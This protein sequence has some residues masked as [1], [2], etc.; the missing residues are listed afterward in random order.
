MRLSLDDMEA[1]DDLLANGGTGDGGQRQQ[2]PQQQRRQL[3][4]ENLSDVFDMMDRRTTASAAAAAQ[5]AAAPTAAAGSGNDNDMRVIYKIKFD[6]SQQSSSSAAAAAPAAVLSVS[7]RPVD[8]YTTHWRE[9]RQQ[10]AELCGQ[11]LD[12]TISKTVDEVTNKSESN[13][14]STSITM[15]SNDDKFTDKAAATAAAAAA[16]VENNDFIIVSNNVSTENQSPPPKTTASSSS[17]SSVAADAATQL[18][19]QLIF[20]TKAQMDNIKNEITVDVTK[21]L[22]NKL[23]ECLHELTSECSST[24]SGCS[25]RNI[26]IYRASATASAAARCEPRSEPPLMPIPMPNDDDDL[27]YKVV[28]TG[29]ICD[30]CDQQIE[31]MRYKCINCLDYDLCEQC[32]L[33][34]EVHDP[35]HTFTVIDR[36]IRQFNKTGYYD[37]PNPNLDFLKPF[38]SSTIVDPVTNEMVLALDVDLRNG[39]ITRSNTTGTAAANATTAPAA[40]APPPPPPQMFNPMVAAAAAASAA[41]KA[42]ACEATAAA[43]KASIEAI[44][45]AVKSANAVAAAVAAKSDVTNN[46]ANNNSGVGDNVVVVDKTTTTTTG[47]TNNTNGLATNPCYPY[48]PQTMAAFEPPP[49]PQVFPKKYDRNDKKCHKIAKKL[50]K[51]RIKNQ[52]MLNQSSDD[53]SAQSS[54]IVGSGGTVA[55]AAGERRHHERNSSRLLANPYHPHPSNPSLNTIKKLYL[56]GLLVEDETIPD[57]TKLPPNARFR[58]TWKVRNTG[59]KVWT[60]RTTLRFVWGH[61][62]LQPFGAITEVQVPPLR[63]GEE[64]KVSIRF[65]APNPKQPT[66]YQSHWRLHHRGQPF[67]QRLECKVIVDPTSSD[68]PT[69]PIPLAPILAAKDPSTTTTTTSGHQSR[70]NS[71]PQPP[72]MSVRM[73]K[74][75]GGSGHHNH[76]PPP[77]LPTTTVEQFLQSETNCN[78][79]SIANI[80]QS[81]IE[82]QRQLSDKL[83]AMA[84]AKQLTTGAATT[85]TVVTAAAQTNS[86]KTAAAAAQK[87]SVK[88]LS[89]ALHAV[90]ELRFDLDNND[91]CDAIPI[92]PNVK[93]H[94]TTPANTPFNV[95]PPKSPEPQQSSVADNAFSGHQIESAAAAATD[96][97]TKDKSEVSA[98]KAAVVV[99]VETDDNNS[100]SKSTEEKPDD[101]CESDVESVDVLSLS[102]NDSMDEFVLV[103]LPTC[104]DL[105]VPFNNNNNNNNGVDNKA[106][107]E[108]DD[109]ETADDDTKDEVVDDI[110]GGSSGNSSDDNNTTTTTATNDW[111]FV[112]IVDNKIGNNNI[113]DDDDDN[114]ELQLISH[115]DTVPLLAA[116]NRAEVVAADSRPATNES[117]LDLTKDRDNDNS[118]Q[119]TTT[120]SSSSSSSS[121]HSSTMTISGSTAVVVDNMN[122]N[123]PSIVA[124]EQPRLRPRTNINNNNGQTSTNPFRQNSNNNSGQN[125]SSTTTTTSSTI[126]TTTNTNETENVIHVLPESIVTGALSAAAHVYNNVSRALFSRNEGTNYAWVTSPPPAAIPL[127]DFW[128]V[129]PPHATAN[130]SVTTTTNQYPMSYD[131]TTGIPTGGGGIGGQHPMNLSSA[132]NTAQPPP[133]PPPIHPHFNPHPPPPPPPPQHHHHHHPMHMHPMAPMYPNLATATAYM[134][135]T[136]NGSTF[137]SA[138]PNG[139]TTYMSATPAG[140]T[141]MAN[142]GQAI[143]M[144][145]PAPRQQQQQQQR[146]QQQQQSGAPN[147]MAN[148]L[149]Q[150]YEMG[151]WNQKLNQELLSKNRMDV[152]DT[153]EEL[154]S[155]QPRSDTTTTDS[156]PSTTTTTTT[157][158]SSSTA[159]VSGRRRRERLVETAV[160]S[161]QPIRRN[162]QNSSDFIEEFD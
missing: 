32:R 68:L 17:R 123:E 156:P 18:D 124:D 35:K 28:H 50:E 76:Q 22:I 14:R 143:P 108:D 105:N 118:H 31:G 138:A 1:A 16:A 78:F 6:G 142:S 100:N 86:E 65:T 64:G 158:S 139:S 162:T 134:S 157:S 59:T 151:F 140:P 61:T 49:P 73:A 141:F 72:K 19:S 11:P 3:F 85:P 80:H 2:R 40:T 111:R 101:D 160:V 155:P 152:N 71:V 89:E 95:S 15:A 122:T 145:A 90:K 96:A 77:L 27:D 137:M 75:S 36:Y 74:S 115:S 51:L 146:Q 102:S 84:T 131:P 126:T 114:E 149:K 104:F 29:I 46:N 43:N 52:V 54:D 120:S 103:P 150:L 4:A 41:A 154:L 113:N 12:V 92:K 107:E 9:V 25:E 60:G 42:A 20:M 33:K 147:R 39:T 45:A 135:A 34:P 106:F 109:D 136:P 47:A 153:I 127:P 48:V 125:T 83:R 82:S 159:A 13:N 24:A 7:V 130:P 38:L 30:S 116:E 5:A 21:R 117:P 119:S 91:E 44:V 94:T 66:R 26:P 148:A 37:I 58:K 88:R 97:N 81:I 128:T 110:S 87:T 70:V 57:G 144:P 10:V 121:G 79:D 99:V 63:P 98:A 53:R 62:E 23:T 133:P 112:E 55:V 132:P 161:D 56:S 69:L 129:R 8:G 93:S 67:G